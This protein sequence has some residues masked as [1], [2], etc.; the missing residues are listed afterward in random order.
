M[1]LRGVNIYG[2]E[3]FPDNNFDSTL[4]CVIATESGEDRSGSGAYNEKGYNQ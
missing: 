1:A 3:D 4:R 2:E